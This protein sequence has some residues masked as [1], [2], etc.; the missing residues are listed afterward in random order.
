MV[1]K[2]IKHQYVPL[3][4]TLGYLKIKLP[5]TII[6]EVKINIDKIQNDF[7]QSISLTH[8]LAGEIQHEYSTVL[9]NNTTNFIREASSIFLKYNPHSLLSSV[10]NTTSNP[11]PTHESIKSFISQ[12]NGGAW[13]NFQ[14][15]HEYNPVHNH[16]G[17]LS[18][19]IW[20]QIP[21]LIEDEDKYSS[22]TKNICNG[23]FYFIYPSDNTIMEHPLNI[24][25]TMEGYMVI[26]PSI[27]SHTVYPFYSSN[28]YRITLSGNLLF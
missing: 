12:Y 15:K 14:Q 24:D 6:D 18:Y 23:R 13:I 16:A 9:L 2:P 25:K 27:L 7:L 4:N 20:H 17:L 28:D 21:Y 10:R 1:K 19:V 3:T 26:F 22:K 8:T 11:P 5:Q